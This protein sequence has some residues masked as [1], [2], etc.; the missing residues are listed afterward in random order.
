MTT[1]AGGAGTRRL[2]LGLSACVIAGGG[3]GS[4]SAQSAQSAGEERWARVTYISGAS[5]YLDAGTTHGVR[6]RTRVEF[7]RGDSVV[8]VVE[9]QYVSSTRASG[10]LVRGVPVAVGDSGRFQPATTSATLASSSASGVTGSVT[11]NVTGTVTETGQATRA[12]RRRTGTARPVTARLGLRY[13][14]LQTGAGAAGHVTQP[15]FDARIETHRLNGSP[16][17]LV[18]DA[19][20]HRQRTGTGRSVGSTRVYQ[21]HLELQSGGAQPTRIALGRQL[22]TTLSSLGYFDGLMMDRD[23]T[24]WRVGVLAGTQPDA[25]T[26]QPDGAIREAGAWV[27]WH[28]APGTPGVV[29]LTLGGVGSYA[30]GG[31]N[32]EYAVLNAL[33]VRSRLSLFATQ[34]LD[35]N[36]TWRRE[37]E[38]GRPLTWTSTFTTVRVEATRA[39]SFNGGY[40]NRRLVRLYRDFLTPDVA[41]DDAFRRGYFGGATV[42]LPH[43]YA[44]VDSRVSDGLSVGRN[45]SHTASLSATRL[46]SL[47]LAV[48]LRATRYDGP[49]VSGQ[50]QSGSLEVSP[51]GRFRIEV[52]AG[53]R[54]DRRVADILATAANTRWYGVDA[55]AGIGRSWYVMYSH[56]LEHGN[57]DRVLQQYAGLSWRY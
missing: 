49:T 29:Q 2:V 24:H 46:T 42:T 40:D 25:A 31:V 36:R 56:Y 47:G 30:K 35:L 16:F 54:R 5:I 10:G 48:R 14:D 22:A 12:P 9:V 27:Q 33:V 20:A 43:V 4:V 13:L 28:N 57:V 41:F 21:S 15:A 23:L 26:F 50:L 39:L 18:I 1:A 17:G 37:A 45:T 51:G 34:E 53:L 55:D 38:G 8:S 6:E 19:R 52:S 32:R 3:A 7:R 44:T 11:G